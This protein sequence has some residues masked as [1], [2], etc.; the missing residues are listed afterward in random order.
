MQY[1]PLFDDN[2]FEPKGTFRYE[3]LNIG[4]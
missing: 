1:H 4:Q 2:K 3:I